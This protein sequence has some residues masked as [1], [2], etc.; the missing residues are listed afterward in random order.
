MLLYVVK[1][2]TVGETLLIKHVSHRP[3][4]PVLHFSKRFCSIQANIIYG[5]WFSLSNKTIKSSLKGKHRITT[6]FP[7]VTWIMKTNEGIS[8]FVHMIKTGT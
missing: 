7:T 2:V 5:L 6:H 1:D 4:H 8:G 3:P